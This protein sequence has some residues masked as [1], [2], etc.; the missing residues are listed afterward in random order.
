MSSEDFQD[1]IRKLYEENVGNQE[2]VEKTEVYRHSIDAVLTQLDGSI[3][4]TDI[5]CGANVCALEFATKGSDGS[6]YFETI[7]DSS[8]TT[9]A[10]LYSVATRD[11]L[12]KDGSYAHRMIFTSNPAVNKMIVPA[13]PPSKK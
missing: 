1:V 3:H 8:E 10:K 6:S 5:A 12:L 7:L 2:A 11:F 9:K 4:G 13:R